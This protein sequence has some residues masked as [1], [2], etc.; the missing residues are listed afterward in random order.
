[1]WPRSHGTIA[2]L[3]QPE[4]CWAGILAWYSIIQ[5]D[6]EKLLETLAALR[7][8]QRY[9]ADVVLFLHATGIPCPPRGT[10]QDEP[11]SAVA[12]LD[13]GIDF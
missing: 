13:N 9:A 8:A 10:A 4:K 12:S 7:R 2:D 1:M 11:V 5:M 6:R 3:H